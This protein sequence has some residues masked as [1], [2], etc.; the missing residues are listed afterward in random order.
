MFVALSGPF[1][2]RIRGSRVAGA[3]LDGVNVA[4]LALMAVVTFH[5]AQRTMTSVLPALMGAGALVALARYRVNATWLVAAGALIG[6]SMTLL[7]G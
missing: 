5:I 2:P 6:V 3:V 4:S 7:Q 1:V